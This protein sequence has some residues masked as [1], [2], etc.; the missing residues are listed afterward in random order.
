MTVEK[1]LKEFMLGGIILVLAATIMALGGAAGQAISSYATFNV[2]IGTNTITVNLGFIPVIVT[3]IGG[4]LLFLYGWRKI[5][6]AR[7]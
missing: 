2:T 6:R 7:I 5:A 1:Y 3:G 4:V